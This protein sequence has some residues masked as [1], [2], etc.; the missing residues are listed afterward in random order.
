MEGKEEEK[1][2]KEGYFNP[3]LT[4]A[5][6]KPHKELSAQVW[7]QHWIR[8]DKEQG[9]RGLNR[10]CHQESVQRNMN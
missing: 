9:W 4:Q 8:S 10:V 1:I 6:M 5:S 3:G 7:V 2:E